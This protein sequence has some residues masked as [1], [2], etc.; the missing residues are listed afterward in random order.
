MTRDMKAF[1]EEVRHDFQTFQSHYEATLEKALQKTEP[2]L[3]Q[4]M[5][6]A[7]ASLQKFMMQQSR[8]APKRQGPPKS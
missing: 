1:K 3:G 2:K 4:N 8:S 7:I 5:N 6:D